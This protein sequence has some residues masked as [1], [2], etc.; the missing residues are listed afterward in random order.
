[1]VG[2]TQLTLRMSSIVFSSGD[3]PPWIQRNCLFMMAARGREQKDSIHASY[4]RSLYLCLPSSVGLG[5]GKKRV[6][7]GSK[8][9]FQFEREVIS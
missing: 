3:R 8:L 4:T 6:V 2:T 9:T 5:S 7:K 1:M